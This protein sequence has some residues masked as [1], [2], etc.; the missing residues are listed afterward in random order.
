MVDTV[1]PAGSRRKTLGR[2]E[3]KFTQ[4]FNVEKKGREKVQV[5]QKAF[6]VTRGLTGDRGIETVLLKIRTSR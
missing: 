3:R 4:I 5:C 6:L 1:N 2:K